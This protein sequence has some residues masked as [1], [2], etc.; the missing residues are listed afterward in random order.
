MEEKSRPK[1]VS[2]LFNYFCSKIMDKIV[3]SGKDKLSLV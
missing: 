1:K 3:I 2:Y